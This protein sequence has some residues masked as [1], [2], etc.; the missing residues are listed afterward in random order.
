MGQRETLAIK[1]VYFP[2]KR[3]VVG[4]Q[5]LNWVDYNDLKIQRLHIENILSLN[6]HQYAGYH[7]YA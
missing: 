2:C 6:D 3:P 5:N 7:E 1:N 4:S